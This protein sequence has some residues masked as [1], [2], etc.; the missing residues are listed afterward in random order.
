[1][2]F[3]PPNLSGT[4]TFSMKTDHER[5]VASEVVRL[6][7]SSRLLVEFGEKI[8]GA[9]KSGPIRAEDTLPQCRVE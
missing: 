1:M 8:G 6:V 4:F 2:I 5:E 9:R 3:T 7:L